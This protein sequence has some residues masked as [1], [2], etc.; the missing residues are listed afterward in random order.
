MIKVNTLRNKNVLPLKEEGPNRVLNSLCR[1]VKALNKI[2][3][4]RLGRTQNS[5]GIIT[6]KI[7]LL[8]Q[9]ELLLKEEVGSKIENK[10]VIMIKP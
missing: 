4:V 10:L 1:V 8:I 3:E 2:N 6:I 9:L 7:R 5:V